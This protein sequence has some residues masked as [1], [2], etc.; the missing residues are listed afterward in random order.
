MDLFLAAAEQR[1][2]GYGLFENQRRFNDWIEQKTFFGNTW[3]IS[4]NIRMQAVGLPFSFG[5]RSNS[6]H[7]LMH[8]LF[9]TTYRGTYKK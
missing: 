2:N 3:N 5:A 1:K 7:G 6:F 8:G 9:L 4:T